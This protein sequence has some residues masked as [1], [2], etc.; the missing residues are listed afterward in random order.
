MPKKFLKS[1]NA[2]TTHSLTHTPL[3][4]TT[5][6]HHSHTPLT[7]ISG[8]PQTRIC[9][10]RIRF[11]NNFQPIEIQSKVQTLVL[12]NK[13]VT[14]FGNQSLP[15]AALEPSQSSKNVDHNLQLKVYF[16]RT[17]LTKKFEMIF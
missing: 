1:M 11:E 15:I 5:H 17:F 8:D 6:T 7:N 3:T 2:H 14:T 12:E 16:R 4:H 10:C 9:H 13:I